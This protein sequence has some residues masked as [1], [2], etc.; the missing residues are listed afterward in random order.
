MGAQCVVNFAG[1][2]LPPQKSCSPELNV[3]K[4]TQHSF[5]PWERIQ[6][7]GTFVLWSLPTVWVEGQYY[8]QEPRGK[9]GR[10]Q[11]LGPFTKEE[12][13]EKYGH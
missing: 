8:V 10:K 12:L 9:G 7:F 6:P 2:P 13:K 3:I 1:I 5:P 11:F 4:H